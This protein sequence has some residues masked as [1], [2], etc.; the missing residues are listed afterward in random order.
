MTLLSRDILLLVAFFGLA[1]RVS[2]QERLEF[3]GLFAIALAAAAAVVAYLVLCVLRQRA[4]VSTWLLALA[5][6]LV[7]VVSARSGETLKNALVFWPALLPLL[8]RRSA[9]G[10]TLGAVLDLLWTVTLGLVLIDVLIITAQASLS[11]ALFGDSFRLVFS[12]RT[13]VGLLFGLYALHYVTHAQDDGACRTK[14]LQ[15]AAVS[16]AIA[17]TTQSF[18]VAL[19]LVVIAPL[20]LTRGLVGRTAILVALI[21]IAPLFAGDLAAVIDLK[22]QARAI[23]LFDEIDSPRSTAEWLFGLV[24]T[25]GSHDY[26]DLPGVPEI[27]LNSFSLPFFLLNNFGA[28]GIGSFLLLL[29]SA[30][31]RARRAPAVLLATTVVSCLHPVHLQL[32]FMLLAT[33]LTLTIYPPL[34]ETCKQ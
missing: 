12:E 17:L 1:S 3:T 6:A 5:I 7:V 27:G 23:A 15:K 20:V 21:A 2:L 32:E 14:L 22:V 33:L 25:R 19:G 18:A 28:V 24:E 9:W 26:E 29:G 16:A 11:E 34:E 10:L 31:R 4:Q 13:W 30:V 8:L